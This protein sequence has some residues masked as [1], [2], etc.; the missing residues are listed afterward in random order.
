VNA[1]LAEPD[2]ER[3]QELELGKNL[4]ALAR[5]AAAAG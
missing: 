5:T 3:R 4:C 1:G 2:E